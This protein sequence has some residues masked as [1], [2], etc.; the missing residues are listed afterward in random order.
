MRAVFLDRDGT[1]IDDKGYTHKVSDLKIY[2]EALTGL[3]SLK[4]EFSFFIVTNQSGV[5]RGYFS[6]S[7]LNQFHEAM[8]AEFAKKGVQF[9]KIYVCP[10]RPDENCDCRKPKSKFLKDAEREFGVDLK[11]SFVIGD[12][13]LDV[14]MAKSVGASGILV[15]TGAPIDEGLPELKRLSPHYV[16]SHMAMACRYVAAGEAK[17]FVAREDLKAWA[18]KARAEKKRIVTVNGSFDIL[19]EGHEKIL[20]EAK[21]QGDLFLVA[22]NSDSSIQEYKSKDRPI[23]NEC[24]RLKMMAQFEMVDAVTIFTETTPMAWL[25]D[26]R[27]DVHVNG[28]EYGE[29]CL[30]APTVRKHG[31]RL[32]IVKLIEGVSTTE[33]LKKKLEARGRE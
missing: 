33:R 27:P 29:N 24:A 1:L 31:G 12:R 11:N 25:E 10:H 18:E 23:N 14:E 16:A 8:S 28:S 22:L 17:K 5:N 13:L 3:V 32:H 6:A 19:H 15:L 26:V 9:Q 30:E 21:A 4:N 7:Q 20:R 2:P